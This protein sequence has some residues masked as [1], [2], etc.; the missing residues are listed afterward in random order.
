MSGPCPGSGTDD[1]AEAERLAGFGDKAGK[2]IITASAGGIVAVDGHGC[3]RVCNPAA[4]EMFARPAGELLGTTFGYPIAADRATEIELMLPEGGRRVVEMRVTSTTLEGERLYIASLRDVTRQR[5]QEQELEAALDR[6]HSVVAVAAH[7]LRNPLAAIGAL[8][9]ALRDPPGTLT[10]EQRMV[11][12]DRIAERAAYLQTLTRKLLTVSRI[13]AR[14]ES[15]RPLPV[16]LL[17]FILEHLTGFDARSDEVHVSCPA[18]LTAL[19]DPGEL[20][21]MLA[22]LLENAFTHGAPPVDVSA[23]VRRGWIE[24]RVCDKGAGVPEDFASQLFE[25][26]T[27]GPNPRAHAGSGLGLWIVRSLAQ[28]NGGDVR[29][30]RRKG[31]GACFI[32]RLKPEPRS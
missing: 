18:S 3:I 13:D 11:I 4:E 14:P 1:D 8:A 2:A 10:D 25:R 27:R 9:H 22:N 16:S 7:E 15:S 24:L 21:E 5:R 31:G 12:A 23:T 30:R 17:G 28:A 19:V 20:S 26:F 32:I 6:E 29:H